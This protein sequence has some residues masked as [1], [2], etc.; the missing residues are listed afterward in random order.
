VVFVAFVALNEAKADIQDGL[1]SYWA[2]DEGGGATTEDGA[3][4]N[5]GILIGLGGSAP[6]WIT[7]GFLG[8]S[9][10]NCSGGGV[11]L[12][13]DGVLDS[14]NVSGDLMPATT[15]SVSA[16]VKP[17][18]AYTY[19]GA[20]LY[21][22]FW[23]S[24][25]QSGFILHRRE[26]YGGTFNLWVK[27]INGYSVASAYRS[28]GSWYHLA[29][30]YDG[31]MVRLYVN[32]SLAGQASL[33][34][35]MDWS[36]V[37]WNVLIGAYNDD[38]ENYIF[39]G[40]IDD[41]GFWSRV[42]TTQEIDFLYNGGSGNPV[43]G[44]DYVHVQITESGEGTSVKEGGTADSYEVVLGAEPSQDV[45]VTATPGDGQIDLGAGAGV[46][47]ILTFTTENW[48]T[49]KTVN[50]NAYDD[51]VYEGKQPHLTTITHSAEGA[52]YTGIS[53]ASVEVEVIDDELICGDWGYMRGDINKDCYVDLLDFAEFASE[54]MASL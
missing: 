12:N 44:G 33:S 19:Y 35:V 7:P 41:V 14:G 47:I 48:A 17:S 1:I 26:D 42:L 28:A 9:H 11:L 4:E 39:Q 22:G 25:T 10:I 40:E 23:T 34:G 31:S 29:G 38:N 6:S 32:G 36:P 2:L 13:S 20:I 24:S 53:I 43:L 3:G 5:N 51:D 21:D 54:W 18:G 52:E 8:E 30:S 46:P 37:P 16:W 27:S 45:Q 49:P 15:F 50:V